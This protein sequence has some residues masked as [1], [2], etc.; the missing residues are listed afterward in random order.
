MISASAGA[1]L[2]ATLAAVAVGVTSVELAGTTALLVGLALSALLLA[3]LAL[4]AAAG[5]G[6]ADALLAEAQEAVGH[7]NTS[8]EIMQQV[9]AYDD[10]ADA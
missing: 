9:V 10:Q 3:L 6:S 8:F 2:A 4:V 5:L 1:V 7:L